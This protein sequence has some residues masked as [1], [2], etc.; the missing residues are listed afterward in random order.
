MRRN[1]RADKGRH[2]FCPSPRSLGES[3][4]RRAGKLRRSLGP[5]ATVSKGRVRPSLL[6]IKLLGF[7]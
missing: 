7:A 1:N 3:I 5:G 4:Q 6:V 2:F